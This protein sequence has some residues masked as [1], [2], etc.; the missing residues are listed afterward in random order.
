M[1]FNSLEYMLVLPVTPAL[2]YALPGRVRNPFLLAASYFFYMWWEPAYALLM[3]F[4]T[5]VTYGCALAMGS[6]R[7][8]GAHRR[9]AWLVLCLA[10]NLAILFFF[11]Y[12]NF[13]A[14]SVNSLL[15]R[16]SGGL[17]ALDILLPV[18][19]S[20]YT[21]QA[22]GYTVDV[23]R[24]ELEPERS[25]IDYALFVSFFPQLVAGPIE[26][27]GNILPQ[28]KKRHRLEIRN[29]PGSV[30]LILIGFCKKMVIADNLA[31]VVNG[32]FADPSAYTGAQ[33]AFASLCFT[34]QIYCDFSAYTD[35]ARGSA[36]LFGVSVMENFRAPFFAES[37]RDFWRRW[38][39]SLSGWFRSY[40][41]I[42]LGGSR[43]GKWRRIFNLMVVF[44]LSGLW[45]GAAWTF[46]LWGA[47]HGLYQAVGVLLDPVRE[48]LYMAVPKN[49]PAVRAV[50]I[51]FTF[52]LVCAA[53]VVFRAESIA[54]AVY[55]LKSAALAPFTG[56]FPL[57]FGAM[58]LTRRMLVVVALHVVLLLTYDGLRDKEA[59]LGRV[60]ST[61]WQKYALGLFLIFSILI[62]GSYGKEVPRQVFVY[63]QF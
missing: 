51:L 53:F 55:I 36:R 13:L 10:V 43:V 6:A 27:A 50:R 24:G 19:I 28:L 52:T 3:L 9:R 59:F 26:R 42:P 20:F 11:K 56:L 15:G 48:R 58:G 2:Y 18:G 37:I 29:L 16:S 44:L 8:G 47:V 23:Y 31:V 1:N 45:H 57:A 41:Y 35:I 38:H 54:D 7:E 60:S 30:L 46:V 49:A 5:A 33:L 14:S 4:S 40:V 22:L 25:F 12:Y 62:F 32:A 34:F 63:F 21:F 61:V 17:P 39:I